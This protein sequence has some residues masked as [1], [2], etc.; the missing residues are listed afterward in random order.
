MYCEVTDNLQCWSVRCLERKLCKNVKLL[1]NNLHNV[2][3]IREMK[4]LLGQRIF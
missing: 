2:D 3:N 4:Q 1:K